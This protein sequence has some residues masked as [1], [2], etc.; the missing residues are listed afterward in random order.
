MAQRRDTDTDPQVAEV[1][2]NFKLAQ[3]QKHSEK[4]FQDSS[5]RNLQHLVSLH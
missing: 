3:S 4:A 2:G 5:V 1:T